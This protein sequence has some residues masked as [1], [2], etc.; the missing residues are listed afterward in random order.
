[1]V[2]PKDWMGKVR[3]TCVD[4]AAPG[5]TLAHAADERWLSPLRSRIDRE[6]S[7][8]VSGVQSDGESSDDDDHFAN[9][10]NA[11]VATE[12]A[13]L[14]Q[15]R[16]EQLQVQLAH[17]EQVRQQADARLSAVDV[18]TAAY[19][20]HQPAPLI[21]DELIPANWIGQIG[22]ATGEPHP[23]LS[24][25]AREGIAA[26]EL[27]LDDAAPHLDR[28][29]QSGVGTDAL[30][31]EG[32]RLVG[33]VVEVG[34]WTSTIRPITDPAFRMSVQLLRTNGDQSLLGAQ[35][36]LSGGGDGTCRMTYVDA[37]QPV[38][39]GD[40]IVTPAEVPHVPA[41]LLCGR[42]V[43][44]RLQEGSLEWLIVVEPAVSMNELTTVAI[45][46]QSFRNEF[47]DH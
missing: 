41:M 21:A 23:L 43:E 45:L 6:R 44:A 13:K 35:G 1:M 10:D 42:V 33:R 32:R 31:L 12:E 29:E 8:F 14:W 7:R 5:I 18:Q 22:S 38:V 36:V 16:C 25:G 47:S 24:V 19:L 17:A 37:T 26:D 46:H 11:A 4:A 30:V 39:V 20:I 15:A 9:S 28:G 27:V 3:T 34:R 2:G 40:L